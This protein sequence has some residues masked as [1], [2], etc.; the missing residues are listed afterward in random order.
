MYSCRVLEKYKWM[1]CKCMI[2]LLTTLPVRRE[3][4]IKWRFPVDNW[5]KAMMRSVDRGMCLTTIFT[6]NSKA[7]ITPDLMEEALVHL[8]G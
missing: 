4:G 2:F 7:P 6:L 5:T 8:Y 3:K 1:I